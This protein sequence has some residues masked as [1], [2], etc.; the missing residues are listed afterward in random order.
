MFNDARRFWK[1]VLQYIVSHVRHK[2]F[3]IP[4]IY[5]YSLTHSLISTTYVASPSIGGNN[6]IKKNGNRSVFG[7]L[8]VI[9]NLRE[10]KKKDNKM[11]TQE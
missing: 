8:I 7:V 4:H 1:V 2:T 6:D 3:R 11:K 9:W 5:T 10:F